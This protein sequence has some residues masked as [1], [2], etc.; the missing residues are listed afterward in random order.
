MNKNK[1]T[2]PL[3]R[4]EQRNQII[5]GDV[6]TVLDEL[7][8]QSIDAVITSPPYF[9]LRNYGEACQIGLE[10]RV[11]DWVDE[12]RLVFRGLKRVLKSTGSVWLNLGDSYAKGASDGAT[13]K[14]LLLA[15]ERLAL[16][17]V[18]DGWILRSKIVWSKTNPLP[19]SAKDRLSCT[20]E[21]IYFLSLSEHYYF[22]LNAIRIPHVS[23]P[24]TASPAAR[25]RYQKT[26]AL[27]EVGA[28]GNL[29][30]P[31]GGLDAFGSGLGGHP[32]GKNPGDV[33][34]YA[35]GGFRGG[36]I[37]VFPERLIDRP[38]LAGV[39]AATCSACG[40][41]WRT[42]NSKPS[43]DCRA[44]TRPGVVLD[45]FMGSG[46][47]G[48][49]AERHGRDWLGIELKAQ[50]RDLAMQRITQERDRHDRLKE[51]A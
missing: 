7:P 38:V 4:M 44:S 41:P 30:A 9:R 6:R 2:R 51:A 26:R 11:D 15:P 18:E 36:H 46:T 12:L 48:V 13:R 28:R 33:W 17:L 40:V 45:P 50:Y 22:D 21:V 10:P 34:R 32:L 24:G 5:V 31:T 1:R 23:G 35:T 43:C 3:L 49:V 27:R 37:A 25:A 8:A 29:A 19:S 16:A 14:S 42:A 20:W 47:V 39:P